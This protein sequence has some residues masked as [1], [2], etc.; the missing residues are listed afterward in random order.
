M[1]PEKLPPDL[2]KGTIAFMAKNRVTAN[3][4]MLVC[5]IGGL[6]MSTRMTK[7]VFPDF[8][9]EYIN[10][11]VSYPGAT[12]EDTEQGIVLPIEEAVRGIEGVLEM[13]SSASEG[14]GRVTLE[15]SPGIDDQ[16]FYQEVQA[17]V[18]RIRT[19]PADAEEP[20]IALSSR[21]RDVLEIQ[22]FGNIEELPLRNLA[23]EVRDR[24]VAD[25]RITLVELD[26]ARNLEIHIRPSMEALRRYD[27]SLQTIASRVRQSSVEIPGG[28]LRTSGGEILVRFDERRDYAREF[29]QIPILTT[30]S[31]AVIHLEDIAEV[32]EEFQ[33]RQYMRT[34]NGQRAIGL[35]IYRVG[36]ETPPAVSRAVRE[37]M[38]DIEPSLPDGVQ[39]AVRSDRSTV[40]SQRLNLLSK[41]FALGLVLVL[42][43]LGLFLEFRLAFWV[44][45]GIPISFLGSF[46]FLPGLDASLNVISMFAF[47]V[48]LGIVV[49]DA[50]VV[51]ENIF[52]HRERGYPPLQAAIIGARQVAVPVTFSIITNCVAFMPLLF[53]PG[54]MGKI[55]GVI[56]VVTITVFLVS[57]FEALYILPAHLAHVKEKPDGG[58]MRGIFRFQQKVSKLIRKGIYNIYGPFLDF[59]MRFRYVTVALSVGLLLV[60]LAYVGSG[61]IGMTLM[62]YVESDEAQVSATLP[63]GAPMEQAEQVRDQIE[64]A[65]FRIIEENGGDQL[66]NGIFSWISE[67][68]VRTI[69]Y[70]KPPGVRPISTREF[71]IRWRME[72]GRIPDLQQLRYDS[73][74][75]GPGGGPGLTVELAHADRDVLERAAGSL[76]DILTQFP[77]A[78][79]IDDGFTPGKPEFEFTLK[80]E[81]RSL[82]LTSRDVA[83]QI[84]SA[85]YGS[86]AIRQL[87]GRNE[88]RVLVQLPEPE[89]NSQFDI[90]QLMIRTPAGAF[91]PLRQ[92]ADFKKERSYTTI[93]RRD[94]KRTLNVS[95]NIE[96]DDQTSLVLDTLK[97]EILPQLTNDFPGLS[98]SFEGREADRQESMA[99]L[100]NGLIVALIVIF[101]LLAIPFNS[102]FQPA[103]VMAALPFGLVGAVMG[104]I[105]MGYSLSVISFM[106]IIALCGVVINDSLIMIVFANGQRAEG[107][108]AFEAMHNAGVRRFRPIFLTTMTTFFGLAPMIFETSLQAKFLIPM[109]ISLGYGLVF[110]TAIT[111]VLIPSL[112]MILEDALDLYARLSG[113]ERDTTDFPDPF[114]E[115]KLESEARIHS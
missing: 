23:E 99:A 92:I 74:R 65:A 79:D 80:P 42:G 35:E 21:R 55:W 63:L 56:P 107:A 17:A 13:T 85:F 19:F 47:I 51:G 77:Y 57:L 95:A 38:A 18:D 25:P 96:P 16:K 2:N 114:D 86:E 71:A 105:L 106:G 11:S 22:L 113:K 98:F 70:L 58:I 109:A 54:F 61:R 81:G 69:V 53:V 88:V 27:L 68:N 20:R 28:S 8:E 44:T 36:K 78:N 43:L 14:S 46:L 112:Y 6:Y 110:A 90:E 24:L 12:P 1:S 97:R 15:Y 82:G 115:S 3:L 76:G 30:S 59:T 10:I 48:T 111:L 9:L 40:Y 101:I 93:Q 108:S 4:L 102:Y 83:S 29:A 32:R 7:E 41:N 52:E 26:G 31:G 50:I 73:S 100:N 104:H 37:I 87:R 64:A 33:D 45:M 89:A 94:G 66:V 84:R 60:I 67:N 91:V 34:F 75:G 72:T 49:D 103:I 39:Y 62:P 5:L